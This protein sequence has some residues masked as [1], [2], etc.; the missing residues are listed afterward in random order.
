MRSLPFVPLTF[1]AGIHGFVLFAA[2]TLAVGATL[3]I[4]RRF[5]A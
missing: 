1:L 4:A 5:T 2:Y 3:L